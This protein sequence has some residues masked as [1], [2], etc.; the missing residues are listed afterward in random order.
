VLDADADDQIDMSPF[1]S[2]LAGTANVIQSSTA[3]FAMG[4]DGQ[5][6]GT[7]YLGKLRPTSAAQPPD[8]VVSWQ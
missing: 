8:D 4:K 3:A 5:R 1:F 6:G 7:G 2:D